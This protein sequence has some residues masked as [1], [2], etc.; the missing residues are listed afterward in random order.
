MYYTYKNAIEFSPDEKR[1]LEF[2]FSRLQEK[3]PD[4]YRSIRKLFGYVVNGSFLVKDENIF[5]GE[6]ESVTTSPDTPF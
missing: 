3:N 1:A 4:L 6:D 5:H 2:V